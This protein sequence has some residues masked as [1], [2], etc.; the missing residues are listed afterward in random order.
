MIRRKKCPKGLWAWAA[1]IAVSAAVG[2][3][4]SLGEVGP[5][6][7]RILALWIVLPLAGA[8]TACAAVSRGGLSNYLAWIAPPLLFYS[9]HLLLWGYAPLLGTTL[10]CAGLSLVGAAAGEVMRT[11]KKR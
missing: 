5:I 11:Q 8:A 6:W 9:V 7:M 2:L 10:I 3:G 1:Q 4:A